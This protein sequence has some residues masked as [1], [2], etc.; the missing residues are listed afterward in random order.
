MIVKNG[1][2]KKTLNKNLALSQT[3]RVKRYSLPLDREG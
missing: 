2:Y 1:I 3:K